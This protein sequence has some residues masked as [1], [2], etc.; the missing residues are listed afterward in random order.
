MVRALP[1]DGAVALEWTIVQAL[2][3][4]RHSGF[5]GATP[6]PPAPLDEKNVAPDSRLDVV[7]D[8]QSF[9]LQHVDFDRLYKGIGR[10]PHMLAGG[11]EHVAALR[12]CQARNLPVWLLDM[13]AAVADAKIDIYHEK[14]LAASWFGVR[15]CRSTNEGPLE[16]RFGVPS[17]EDCSN[18][19]LQGVVPKFLD[20]LIVG[21]R[22]QHMVH[23]LLSNLHR[24]EAAGKLPPIAV[25][26]VGGDHVKGIE[27]HWQ[28]VCELP[29]EKHQEAISAL[30]ALPPPEEEEYEYD[31]G[32]E[33]EEAQ[34]EGESESEGGERPRVGS[35]AW[36]ACAPEQ[37]AGHWH[38][39]VSKLCKQLAESGDAHAPHKAGVT[40]SSSETDSSSSSS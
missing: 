8:F 3:T 37:E 27:A 22:D 40:R 38:A 33:E 4:L 16:P 21:E 14:A 15:P 9:F 20:P 30:C 39:R 24:C 1:K 17:L 7:A 34:E 11:V 12:M 31:Y 19:L 25:A 29:A 26:F 32:D 6:L 2:V 28:E 36:K 18:L 5:D 35:D 13:P 23:S 10:Y